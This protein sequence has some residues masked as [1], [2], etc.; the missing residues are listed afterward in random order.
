[1]LVD[2][3]RPVVDEL[4]T[5]GE[6]NFVLSDGACLYVHAHTTLHVL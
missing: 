1:V 3:I 6:F 5:L 4:A 2:A